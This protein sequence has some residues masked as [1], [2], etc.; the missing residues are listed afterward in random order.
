VE[1]FLSLFFSILKEEKRK[2]SFYKITKYNFRISPELKV[3]KTKKPDF[4]SG[5]FRNINWFYI[6]LSK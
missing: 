6:R 1:P 5:F 2:C 4:L 3:L